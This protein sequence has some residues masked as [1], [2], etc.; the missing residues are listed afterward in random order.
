[1]SFNVYPAPPSAPLSV[2]AAGTGPLVEI[3]EHTSIDPIT[4][5]T[6]MFMRVVQVDAGDGRVPPVPSVRLA[7]DDGVPVTVGAVPTALRTSAGETVALAGLGAVSDD[8]HVVQIEV[9]RVQHSWRLQV[10]NTDVVEHRYTWVVGDS[11]GETL[12]PWLDVPVAAVAFEALAGGTAP[13]QGVPLVNYAAGSLTVDEPA[14]DLGSGFRLIGIVPRV[15]GGNRRAVASIGFTAPDV[16]GD[17]SITHVF[18]SSDP[19]A[20]PA[21]GHSNRVVLA[22]TVRPRPRWRAADVLVLSGVDL[23]RLERATGELVPVTSD[24]AGAVDAAVDPSTGDALVLG[25]GF[26]VKRVDRFTGHQTPLPGFTHVS[27]P[28]GLA[29]EKNGAILVLDKGTGSMTRTDPGGGATSS[30]FLVGLAD[31]RDLA[32]EGKD[33]NVIVVFDGFAEEAKAVRVSAATGQQSTIAAGGDLSGPVGGPVAVAVER[34]GTILAVR[35]FRFAGG[36]VTV[37]EGRVFRI[38]PDSGDVALL[39]GNYQLADPMALDVAADGS[40]LVAAGAGLFALDPATG[41]VTR[42]TDASV[43]RIVVVP[44]IAD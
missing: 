35:A 18:A 19:G 32:L 38:D 37:S 8:V 1:M 26:G 30:T 9:L 4:G 33:D 41:A 11:D 20:G 39:V 29:V 3:A 25:V 7:V 15:I 36:G 24:V 2:P 10:V 21:A 44:T 31:P 40:V 17:L 42:L 14:T 22:A 16:P 12:Q 28:V 23:C 6:L 34:D 43:R 13:V 27:A 5:R